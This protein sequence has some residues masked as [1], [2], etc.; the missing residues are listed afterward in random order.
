MFSTGRVTSETGSSIL[1]LADGVRSCG[2]TDSSGF[3]TVK[4]NSETLT[5]GGKSYLH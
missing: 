5:M 4:R 3:T 1:V 2:K